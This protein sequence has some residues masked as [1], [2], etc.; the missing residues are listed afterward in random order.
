[1]VGGVA[2][3]AGVKKYVEAKG[4]SGLDLVSIVS[5]ANINFHRLRH[6]S[7]PGNSSGC[8]CRG[9]QTSRFCINPLQTQAW[10]R[11]YWPEDAAAEA[12]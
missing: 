10:R 11:R 6:I 1:M 3:N 4:I 9:L 5:G 12:S 2:L 7:E 8:T